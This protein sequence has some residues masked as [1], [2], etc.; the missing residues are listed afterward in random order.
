MIGNG[1]QRPVHP[2]GVAGLEHSADPPRDRLRIAPGNHLEGSTDA[3]EPGGFDAHDRAGAS[4]D[5]LDD[6]VRRVQ[7]LVQADR[8]YESGCQLA[9][10][11]EVVSSE[12]LLDASETQ[13]VEDPQ[14]LGGV[15][16]VGTI[17]IELHDESG[18]DE[19]PDRTIHQRLQTRS[20]L[21]LHPCIPG[22]VQ[23][24][25]VRSQL[26]GGGRQP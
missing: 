8:R 2:P 18:A 23:A 14:P 17:G 7:A 3:P 4:V 22:V 16:P 19:R 26:F 15:L 24:N 6:L 1:G 20:D 25:E 10:A 5:R 21:D 12:G 13:V 9:M 11:F